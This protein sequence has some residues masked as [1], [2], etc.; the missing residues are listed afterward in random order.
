MD[1]LGIILFSIM[2][3]AFIICVVILYNLLKTQEWVKIINYYAY[4]KDLDP[5]NDCGKL[6]GIAGC[7]NRKE[8]DCHTGCDSAWCCIACSY[9]KHCK[10]PC[11]GVD[12]LI[13][14]IINEE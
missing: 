4:S 7:L 14:T 8:S 6:Q 5:E 13:H 11:K 3:P 12:R 10:H 1:L 9:N 2:I